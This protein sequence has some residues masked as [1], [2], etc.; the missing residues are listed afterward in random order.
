M[1]H[2]VDVSGHQG[3]IDWLRVAAHR[4]ADGSRIEAAAVKL[5]EG[6]DWLDP[7][8]YSNIVGAYAAG[9]DVTAYHYLGRASSGAVQARWFLEHWRAAMVDIVPLIPILDVEHPKD[10]DPGPRAL[11][12]VEAV[13]GEL[14]VAPMLY[15]Y[16]A[17]AGRL[18]EP[19][20]EACPLWIAD[21][22]GRDKAEVP[23]P[24]G[25]PGQS[26]A[27]WQYTWKARIDGISTPV[28]MSH[29]RELLRPS[30]VAQV[31]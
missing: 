26:W 10:P 20:L 8:G 9:L 14:G 5:T 2:V 1:I 27:W 4:F 17:Y 31:G 30:R 24:W 21:V 12:F 28:D 15:T 18:H 25:A 19:A 23:P 16:P 11:A 3:E 29:A 6:G 22:R 7:M 13:R